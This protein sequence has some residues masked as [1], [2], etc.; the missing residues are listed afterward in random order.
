MKGSVT[1]VWAELKG[2]CKA[3]GQQEAVATS[4][5]KG[6]EEE[7]DFADSKERWNQGREPTWQELKSWTG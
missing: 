4:D 6:Q 2:A 1:E 7:R 3:G 5:S